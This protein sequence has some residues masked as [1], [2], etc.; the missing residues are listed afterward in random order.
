MSAWIASSA[1]LFAQNPLFKSKTYSVYP[2]KVIQGEFTATAS[3]PSEIVSN[4]RSNFR[5]QTNRNISFKFCI[6]GLDNERMPG[7]DHHV[8]IPPK[9]PKYVLPVYEFG[10]PDPEEANAPAGVNPF[11]DENVDVVFRVDMRRVSQ[12]FS[13]KGFFTTFAGEKIAA[14]DFRGVYLAGGVDPLTWN[15]AT[16]ESKPEFKLSDPD[17]DSIFE[18]TIR[19]KKENYPGHFPEKE[20]RWML[21]SKLANYPAYESPQVLVDALYNRSLEETMLDIRPDGAF[22]AGESW[23]GVWTRDISYSILLSLAIVH[24]DASKASLMVKVKNGKIIQDTGTGG[25]WPVSTDR[26]VWALAAWEVYCVTGDKTWLLQSYD[27][28]KSSAEDDL[29]TAYDSQTGLFF[30]ESSFLDW[31]EQTYP[32]WM[33]PKDIY[34]SKNLGTN[35]VHYRTYR[36]LSEMAKILGKDGGRYA[37]IAEGVKKGI[38]KYLWNSKAKVY[39]QYLY[40]RTYPVLSPRTEALGEALAVLYD[41]ANGSRRQQIVQNTPITPFGISCIYP[42]IPNIPPYHNNG[43]W[44]FV[45]TYWAWAAAKTGNESSVNAALASLFRPAALFLT[46]KENF[47]AETGDFLGTEINSNRQLWSVAGTLASVYRILFGIECLPDKLTLTPFVPQAYAGNRSLKNLK[48]REYSLDINLHGYGNTIASVS[49][50]GKRIRKAEVPADLKGSHKLDITLGG[51]SAQG[52]VYL[53]SNEFAPETPIVRERNETLQWDAIH[54]AINY[55]ICRN[56]KPIATTKSTS[57][58]LP[59]NDRYAEYQ[60]KA[61]GVNGSE[62]FFSEPIRKV[63]AENILIVHAGD[64]ESERVCV[65]RTGTSAIEKEFQISTSGSYI[66]DVRYANGS[67]PINTDNKCAIRTLVIDGKKVS[68]VILAQRGENNWMEF[69]YS[70]SMKVKLQK[71]KHRLALTFASSNNNMNGETNTAL[72]SH[73]RFALVDDGGGKQ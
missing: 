70:N 33:D 15:F 61:V 48:Y 12:E 52:S 34:Q 39:G 17:S 44:P 26:M 1:A 35:V 57:L 19:F 10:K 45:E 27:I 54:D 71:G 53:V 41:V 28:A 3:S 25:S 37:A 18:G 29:Q 2:D 60:V 68:P 4:Y 49:L 47:V 56:G 7:Q 38:N 13:T 58:T 30:G 32:R 22:M 63:P 64:K 69:G 50:D 46:N 59:P 55:I 31:R 11:L 20:R 73:F 66:V 5:K 23:P 72:I 51:E 65:E 16:L 8:I 40:G 6:N 36:I 67:G 14:K 24:P 43:I 42:Q 9:G 21:T 62:S